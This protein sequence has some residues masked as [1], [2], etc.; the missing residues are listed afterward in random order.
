MPEPR[1]EFSDLPAASCAHCTGRTG[2]PEATDVTV[3]AR[4]TARYEGPC[5]TCDRWISIHDEIGRTT[6]GDYICERCL[7]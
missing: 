5:A 4:F 3:V 1:C 2:E 7:P 6:D